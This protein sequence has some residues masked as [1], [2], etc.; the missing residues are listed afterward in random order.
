MTGLVLAGFL[1][2]AASEREQL[3][4]LSQLTDAATLDAYFLS[5]SWVVRKAVVARTSSTALLIEAASGDPDPYVRDEPGGAG[6]A[7]TVVSAG[8]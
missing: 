2:A 4:A 1:F 7:S 6:L 3:A 5:D 8:V